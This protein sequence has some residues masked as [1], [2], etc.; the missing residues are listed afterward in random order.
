[1]SAEK[2]VIHNPHPGTNTKVSKN[3]LKT[4]QIIKKH[5]LGAPSCF[6]L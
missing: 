6:L 2:T 1:M 5:M 3:M 4:K